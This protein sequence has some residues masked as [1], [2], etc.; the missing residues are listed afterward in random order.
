MELYELNYILH[1]PCEEHGWLYMAE[2]PELPGCRAWDET[3]N[4]T[5][6]ELV[7]VAEAF[8]QSYKDRDIP[9]PKGIV[10]PPPSKKGRISVAV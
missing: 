1:E 4:S 7:T 5:L 8:V 6:A 10:S 3:A 2:V 9:L